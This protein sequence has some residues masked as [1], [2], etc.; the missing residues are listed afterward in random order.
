MKYFYPL[1]KYAATHWSCKFYVR[2]SLSDFLLSWEP[3]QYFN[4]QVLGSLF[5]NKKT[6]GNW[7]PRL[8]FLNWFWFY[9]FLALKILCY[10]KEIVSFENYIYL[11]FLHLHQLCYSAMSAQVSLRTKVNLQ[12]FFKWRFHYSYLFF[13]RWFTSSSRRT[14]EIGYLHVPT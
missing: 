1:F 10:I 9:F 11:E 3:G 12:D 8:Y 14:R 4:P 13:E 2:D 7:H 5:K 6:E